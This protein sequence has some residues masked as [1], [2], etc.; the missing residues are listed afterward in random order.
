MCSARKG[1]L[2]N[3][4]KFARKHL[5]RSHFFLMKLQSEACNY[6]KKETVAQLFS[7]EFCEISMNI[8]F[9][10]HLWA[11]ASVPKCLKFDISG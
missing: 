2:G 6:I 3:F 8:V 7:C 11:S 9:T 1:A 4:V 5:C 10:E